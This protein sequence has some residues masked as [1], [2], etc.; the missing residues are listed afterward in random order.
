MNLT[1]RSG[2]NAGHGHRTETSSLHFTSNLHSLPKDLGQVRSVDL[3]YYFGE[4]KPRI[5]FL[6]NAR[7]CLRCNRAL[8]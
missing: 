1:R 8:L 3:N 7:Q 4:A 5:N 2:F 6:G